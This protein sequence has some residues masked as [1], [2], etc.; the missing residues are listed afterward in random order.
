MTAAKSPDRSRTAATETT[1][2]GKGMPAQ[3]PPAGGGQLGTSETEPRD[4]SDKSNLALP[5]ERDQ[6]TDMTPDQPSARMKQAQIDE[7]GPRQDTS[8]A[9]E[10]NDTYQ[11]QK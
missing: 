1:S 3:T 11:K 2:S 9:L 7:A 8:K 5:H 6:W 4:A 10:M